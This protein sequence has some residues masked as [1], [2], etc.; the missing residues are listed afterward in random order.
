MNVRWLICCLYCF[1]W[2]SI[3]ESAR[4]RKKICKMDGS[5]SHMCCRQASRATAACLAG[6]PDADAEAE[7]EAEAR[8]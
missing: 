6:S 3:K 8:A 5:Y 1:P 4:T 2:K 7:A